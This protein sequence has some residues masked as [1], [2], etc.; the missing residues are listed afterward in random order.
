MRSHE[1][2]PQV[3]GNPEAGNKFQ[4]L[5]QLLQ[6]ALDCFGIGEVGNPNC[7]LQ[8]WMAGVKCPCYLFQEFELA[9]DQD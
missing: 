4:K 7:N 1:R 3:V 2:L 6:K 8:G 5:F 9:G